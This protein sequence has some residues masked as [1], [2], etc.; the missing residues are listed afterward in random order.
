MCLCVSLFLLARDSV[1]HQSII[2]L[3]QTRQEHDRRNLRRDLNDF[4]AIYQQF[5]DAREYDLNDV[6][7]STMVYNNEYIRLQYGPGSCLYFEGED[8]NKK[9]REKKQK[10]QMSEWITEQVFA[11]I[12]ITNENI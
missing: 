1:K 2:H 10:E 4:R 12:V 8:Q 9:D 6:M 7:A 5:R 3:L 11:I